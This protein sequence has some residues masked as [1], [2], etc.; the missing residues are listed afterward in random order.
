MQLVVSLTDWAYKGNTVAQVV[1]LGTSQTSPTTL[2]LP[3]RIDLRAFP[4]S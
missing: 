2:T 4:A 3:G 1:T